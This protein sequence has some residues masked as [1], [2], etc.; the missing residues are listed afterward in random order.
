MNPPVVKYL[1]VTL[2]TPAFDAAVIDPHGRFLDALRALGQ[3][4]A[5]GPFGDGSGGAYLLRVGSLAEANAIVARDPLIASGA[6]RATV[7][8]WTVR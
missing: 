2:R 5:Q 8:E 3:L 6:S 4:E 1:V 7:Y